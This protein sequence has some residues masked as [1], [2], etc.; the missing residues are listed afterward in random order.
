LLTPSHASGASHASIGARH[1]LVFFPS[2]GHGADEPEH[3]SAWSQ[4]P[5]AERQTNV[6]GWNASAGQFALEPVH[7]STTSHG[8]ADARHWVNAGL[9]WF[10][11]H[12]PV[13]PL[14]VSA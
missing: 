11:G 14:H 10:A 8:P 7:V 4:M 5:A 1:S 9:N 3:V 2:A 6:D 12:T 13:V